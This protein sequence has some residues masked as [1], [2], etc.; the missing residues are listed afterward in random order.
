MSRE[1]F[2]ADING[3]D[4]RCFEAMSV[5]YRFHHLRKGK[6]SVEALDKRAMLLPIFHLW[7]VLPLILV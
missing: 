1:V 7:P 5:F 4:A 3:L 2:E 6:L